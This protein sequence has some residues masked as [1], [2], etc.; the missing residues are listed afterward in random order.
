MV[1]I[2]AFGSCPTLDA[3]NRAILLSYDTHENRLAFKQLVRF[4]SSCNKFAV[5]QDAA[6]GWFY[7][8]T[9]PVTLAPSPTCGQ[10][11]TV[12][13][14]RSKDLISWQTCS[15][16][17]WDDT[18]LG[19]TD[20]IAHTGLQ[21]IDWRFAN[22]STIV[23]AVRAG[24][25][26]STTYHDANRLLLTKVDDYDS[27]CS[28]ISVTGT[29]FGLGVVQKGLAAFT[30][31]GYVWEDVPAALVGL[32]FTRKMGGGDANITVTVPP[33]ATSAT[34]FAGVCVAEA[35]HNPAGL[36]GWTATGMSM[37]YTDTAKTRV[38]FFSKTVQA[39]AAAFL[40]ENDP[41]WCG[42]I[43]AFRPGN[44]SGSDSDSGSGGGG[45]GGGG[46]TV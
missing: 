25:N 18:G 32:M 29:G 21:Y 3:C 40:V 17:M 13:L 33:A 34:L 2:D 26:G 46:S 7:S 23:A 39:G 9:N 27:L 8:L 4:P 44:G 22:R 11:N 30:N 37:A 16:V 31:R 28:G 19:V 20:S 24:Y 15:V 43:I 38:T 5:R 41:T 35:G 1:R 14:T 12:V 42:T 6:T 45:G 10:R 36:A